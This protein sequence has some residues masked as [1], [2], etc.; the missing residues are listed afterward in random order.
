MDDLERELNG[1]EN[2]AKIESAGSSS[3]PSHCVYREADIGRKRSN[4]YIVSSQ[5]VGI[6]SPSSGRRSSP[7]L[8]KEAIINENCYT[9]MNDN[10][11]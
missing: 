11:V 8:K 5:F 10:V 7:S 9:E 3:C 4:Q 1:L 2:L 6:Q